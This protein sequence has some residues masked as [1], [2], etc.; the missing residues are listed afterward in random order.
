MYILSCTSIGTA[1]YVNVI[2]IKKKNKNKEKSSKFNSGLCYRC[3]TA[4]GYKPICSVVVP[5]SHALTSTNRSFR[6]SCIIVWI[7]ISCWQAYACY[8]RTRILVE[9]PW[10]VSLSSLTENRNERRRI[11]CPKFINTTYNN[12]SQVSER[13]LVFQRYVFF[14]FVFVYNFSG[15]KSRSRF[16]C[17]ISTDRKSVADC[18][19]CFWEVIFR[20]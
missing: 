13:L 16:S 18:T 10:R 17:N 6:L 12:V 11:W 3:E 20:I 7:G 15:G 4:F 5:H 1:V 9:N 8:R 19:S 14:I 2:G